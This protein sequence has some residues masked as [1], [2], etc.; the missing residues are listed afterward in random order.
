MVCDK[1]KP[2]S[3]SLPD[4]NQHSSRKVQQGI[5]ICVTAGSLFC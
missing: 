5:L 3:G 4:V 2:R 1:A